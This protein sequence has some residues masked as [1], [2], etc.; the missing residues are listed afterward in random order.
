MLAVVAVLAAS[1]VGFATPI[2]GDAVRVASAAYCK[3]SSTIGGAGC[4]NAELPGYVPVECTISSHEGAAGGS[5]KIV[6][7]EV[8]ADGSYELAEVRRR[9]DDGTYHVYWV[10]TT[11]R[12]GS[13]G[14]D[15]S[16]GAKADLDTGEGSV[17]GGAE[18]GIEVALEGAGGQSYEFDNEADARRAIDAWKSQNDINIFDSDSIDG[19]VVTEL[20]TG[21]ARVQVYG[22]AGPLSGDAESTLIVGYTENKQNGD[23]T[24]SLVT[25]TEVAAQLGIPL[26]DQVLQLQ[27]EGKASREMGLSL[28]F[29]RAGN[30]VG[31]QA[32]LTGTVHGQLAVGVD[33]GPLEDASNG[34]ITDLDLPG[35]GTHDGGRQWVLTYNADFRR[36]DGTVDTGAYGDAGAALATFV[37]TGQLPLRAN[38]RALHDYLDDRSQVTFDTYDYAED[39]DRY[40]AEVKLGPVALGGEVHVSTQD[41]Q[42][43]TGQYYDPAQGIWVTRLDCGR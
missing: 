17:G 42:I 41:R 26:P 8:G 24:V 11:K 37:A 16:L 7:V 4:T 6:I 20:Y 9:L 36:P 22:E 27:A 32:T 31:V 40:G 23:R 29:D 10:L 5:V 21:G 18:G 15:I 34:T 39:E 13:A 30:L 14:V 12:G 25:T 3:I 28:T 2:G 35:M 1:L 19:E 38:V 43:L 33:T